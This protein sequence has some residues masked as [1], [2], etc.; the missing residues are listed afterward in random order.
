MCS[1]LGYSRASRSPKL[2][3]LHFNAAHLRVYCSAVLAVWA[4]EIASTLSTRSLE[5]SFAAALS[6]AR[7]HLNPEGRELE[8]LL[9]VCPVR[10]GGTAMQHEAT[11]VQVVQLVPSLMA[12]LS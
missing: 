6:G 8:G 10:F 9:Q 11:P 5:L 1:L 3:T 12:T 7:G 4:L 2:C